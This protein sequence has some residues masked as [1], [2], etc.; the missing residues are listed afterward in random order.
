MTWSQSRTSPSSA[1]AR[2]VW[3]VAA[4]LLSLLALAVGGLVWTGQRTN[5]LA[6]DQQLA[7]LSASLDTEKRQTLQRFAR[8][9]GTPAAVTALTHPISPRAAQAAIGEPLEQVLGFEASFVVTPENIVVTGRAGAEPADQR[10]FDARLHLLAPAL[11]EL[12]DKL[13]QL[14]LRRDPIFTSGADPA[15]VARKAGVSRLAFDGGML[16]ILVAVPMLGEQDDPTGGLVAVGIRPLSL[17]SLREDI[18]R[19]NYADLHIEEVTAGGP[20]APWALPVL[21]GQSMMRATL[22]WRP[23]RPGDQVLE[24]VLPSIVIALLAIGL[25]SAFMFAHVRF[26]TT[27][28]V[29]RE[30]R[31]THLALHDP[32]SGLPNRS[33]FAARLDAALARLDDHTDGVAVL[34]IDLDRFKDVN[35]THGHEAGDVLLRIVARRL[36]DAL[37]GADLLARFG[38]D[39]FA[40]M[41]THVRSA[42]DCAALA[43]RILEAMREPFDVGAANVMVG[44]TIGIAIAPENGR[45][46]DTLMKLADQALYRAKN[47]GRNRYA[48]FQIGMDHALIMRQAVDEDLA[49]AIAANELRV[50]YQPQY[51]PDGRT[52]LGVEALVRWP[53]PVHGMIPPSTFVPMA[54]ERGLI[55]QLSEWVLRQA[56]RDGRH[57]P[58]ISVAVNVSPIQF[59]QADFVARTA[60]IVDEEGMDPTRVELE[61]TEGVIVDDADVAEHAMVELRS[62]GF[63]FA[64]DDFGT[65]YS[66][67][68]YLRRFAFDKIKIDRSFLEAMETTGE[69]AILVHSVVHLGRALGLTVTAEGVETAEQQ[70]FLQAVGCHQLQGYL[71]SRPLPAAEIDAMLGVAR[72]AERL[73]A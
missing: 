41:Q 32:L 45:E 30:A 36:T 65:G 18:L 9:V 47:D 5:E 34:F 23:V 68:I 51:S 28:L 13:G 4:V 17:A 8:V 54:E 1:T 48:F 20:I 66:S 42:H 22:V 37:R 29:N 3:P 40:I 19:G 35:D 56:C 64:L 25:F 38:G 6:A 52:I 57:W 73:S 59:R 27:D 39:E 72:S 53:H 63:R 44:A 71:L 26:V 2:I 49:A 46:R 70:R 16:R 31:A 69:S 67:L 10:R 43:H 15:T 58:G 50:H 12:R 61:L 62:L 60:H 55:T 11:A 24:R 14:A 7:T 33:L 21:D